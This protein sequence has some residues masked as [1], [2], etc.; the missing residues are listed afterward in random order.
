MKVIFLDFDGVINDFD[1]IHIFEYNPAPVGGSGA[2]HNISASQNLLDK[3][4][5]IADALDLI[6]A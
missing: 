5:G 6:Q 3:S 4:L 2:D 1:L